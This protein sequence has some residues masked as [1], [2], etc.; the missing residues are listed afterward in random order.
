[1]DISVEDDRSPH[2]D[3]EQRKVALTILAHIN[4]CSTEPKASLPRAPWHPIRVRTATP[5]RPDLLALRGALVAEGLAM[6]RCSLARSCRHALRSTTRSHSRCSSVRQDV[7][8][9]HPERFDAAHVGIDRAGRLAWRRSACA[10]RSPTNRLRVDVAAAALRA[11]QAQPHVRH[12]HQPFELTGDD[13][14]ALAG[15]AF[16][17]SAKSASLN[18]PRRAVLRII[19]TGN[20][21]SALENAHS[22]TRGTAKNNMYQLR[23][24]CTGLRLS[25]ADSTRGWGQLRIASFS[26]CSEWY[27]ASHQAIAPPQS[28]P[29]IGTR[30][31]PIAAMRPITSPVRRSMR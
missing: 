14:V 31:C 17:G 15:S 20:A 7:L 2:A 1:V 25:A 3:R 9:D 4:S 8:G 29:T 10:S 18:V 22:G 13:P 5:R 26:T 27:V 30:L 16:Q 19:E 21:Q 28:W 24:I 12:R 23:R 11:R 6:S